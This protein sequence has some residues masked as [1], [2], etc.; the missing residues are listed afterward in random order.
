MGAVHLLDDVSAVQGPK[1]VLILHFTWIEKYLC[2]REWRPEFEVILIMT[3][4]R[5]NVE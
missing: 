1:K 3:R 2:D 4:L 5:F